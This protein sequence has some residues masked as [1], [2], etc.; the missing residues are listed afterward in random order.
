[1][2]L[3]ESV[4]A[5]NKE[6][7]STGIDLELRSRAQG[8]ARGSRWRADFKKNTGLTAENGKRWSRRKLIFASEGKLNGR[9]GMSFGDPATFFY[10]Y[11]LTYFAIPRAGNWRKVRRVEPKEH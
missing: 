11:V 8:E 5:Q 4:S 6:G 3:E 10:G 1:V 2:S 9:T 7:E